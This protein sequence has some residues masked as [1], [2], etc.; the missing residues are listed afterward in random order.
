MPV[1]NG[2]RYLAQAI[3]SVL[4]QTFSDLELIVIDDGS[5]DHSYDI[6]R[7]YQAQDDRVRIA[8]QEHGGNIV[9]RNACLS[10]ARAP[11]IG[12]LDADDLAHPDWLRRQIGYLSVHPAVVAVGAQAMLFFNDR[13]P[14]GVQNLPLDH[15]GIVKIYMSG[16]GGGMMNG[17]LLMRRSAIDRAGGFNESMHTV[18]DMDLILRLAEDG[19]LANLADVLLWRRVH[20]QSVTHSQLE[21]HARMRLEAARRARQRRGLPPAPAFA[22]EVPGIDAVLMYYAHLAVANGHDL[23]AARL[24][25]SVLRG[26]PGLEAARDLLRQSLGRALFRRRHAAAPPALPPRARLQPAQAPR[27]DESWHLLPPT[28]PRP[29]LRNILLYNP[30]GQRWESSFWPELRLALRNRGYELHACGCEDPRVDLPFVQIPYS[31]DEVRPAETLGYRWA[32]PHALDVEAIL[33]REALF[34][35]DRGQPADR[36][37][38]AQQVATVQGAL[39]A[40]LRPWLVLFW[41]GEQTHQ[42][43]LR[44]LL[45]GT[46]CPSLRLERSP[47]PGVLYADAAGLMSD[48]TFARQPVHWQTQ[49]ERDLW[50]QRFNDYARIING[51]NTTWW[52]DGGRR[53]DGLPPVVPLG[54]MPV[55][56]AGQVDRDT[57]NF[58]FSPWFDSNLEAFRA[59]CRLARLD[60][61]VFIIGKHHPLSESSPGAYCEVVAGTGCWLS[62]IDLAVCLDGV[63]CVAAVNSSVLFEAALR[64]K[65][66]LTLGRTLLHGR[67]VFYDMRAPDDRATFHDWIT[68]HEVEAR[69]WR[70]QETG[71]WLFAR[72]CYSL[73][74]ER[75][76]GLRG[77]E[78]LAEAITSRAAHEQPDYSGVQADGWAALNLFNAFIRVA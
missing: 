18:E 47:F 36:I 45:H 67:D 78:A 5:R 30:S 61:R 43:I 11:L 37:N 48:A 28:G 20:A 1:Y 26:H 72:H 24:A 3:G 71:A 16:T 12:W 25:L 32:R 33:D 35:G 53:A 63:E 10:L 76:A 14:I 4:A 19:V 29:E 21:N 77:A 64:G 27:P 23:S 46:G 39:L 34:T 42:L 69:R 68:G 57:Q 58:F 22:S 65:R 38:A 73:L 70:W 66:C 54:H 15:D 8:R 44:Q 7:R 17:A 6:M 2:E 75:V 74:G 31:L 41:N 49:A 60:G 55:L 40:H 52:G 62:G 51:S 50:M 13:W 59:F 9:C 56:F